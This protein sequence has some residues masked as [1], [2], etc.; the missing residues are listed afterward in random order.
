MKNKKQNN[1][2]KQEGI[3]VDNCLVE[4]EL[5]GGKFRVSLPNGAK[6]ICHI[7]GKMRMK[8]IRVLPMDRVLVEL[9]PYNLEQGIIKYR[10]K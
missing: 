5:G 10:N 9:S 4:E 2:N 6:A 3:A 7:T 1:S 8:K